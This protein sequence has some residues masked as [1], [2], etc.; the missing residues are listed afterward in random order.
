MVQPSLTLLRSKLLG[1]QLSLNTTTNSPFAIPTIPAQLEQPKPPRTRATR[2]LR[3]RLLF[4]LAQ[5][6]TS[7]FSMLSEILPAR[8][9]LTMSS[10]LVILSTSTRKAPTVGVGALVVSH[11]PMLSSVLYMTIAGDMLN[12][13]Q[14]SIPLSPSAPTHGF[15]YVSTNFFNE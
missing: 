8:R 3:F 2:L 1:S 5:T 7:A 12:T 11:S 10:I 6:S 14:I 13:E 9:A 4:T 15:L